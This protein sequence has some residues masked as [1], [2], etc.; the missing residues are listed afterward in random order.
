MTFTN[1]YAIECPR[2]R[3]FLVFFWLFFDTVFSP[4]ALDEVSHQMLS[5]L[6]AAYSWEPSRRDGHP[7][8]NDDSG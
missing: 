1:E 6:E 3:F 4:L 7:G 8:I 2:I 5:A